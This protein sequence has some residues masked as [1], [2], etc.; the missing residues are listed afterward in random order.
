MWYLDFPH[1]F[2]RLEGTAFSEPSLCQGHVDLNPYTE[3]LRV[4]GVGLHLGTWPDSGTWLSRWRRDA[5]DAL[6]KTFSP[7]CALRAT[8]QIIV[9]LVVASFFRE[10]PLQTR[11]DKVAKNFH[12]SFSL[13]SE[14]SPFWWCWIQENIKNMVLELSILPSMCAS[15]EPNVFAA[16]QGWHWARGPCRLKDG[17][18]VKMLVFGNW[19]PDSIKLAHALAGAWASLLLFS[20]VWSGC[21]KRVDITANLCVA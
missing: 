16:D 9:T 1:S 4:C 6:I 15:A 11:I 19:Q 13:A 21:L 7:A 10:F 17:F 3:N 2:G 12:V 20:R 14:W 18:P 5:L 8:L